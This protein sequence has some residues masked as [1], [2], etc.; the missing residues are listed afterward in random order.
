[1]CRGETYCRHLRGGPRP[2]LPSRI[3]PVPLSSPYSRE[4]EA[5]DREMDVYLLNV[6]GQ[7]VV[8]G[9]HVAHDLGY[10]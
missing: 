5:D 4:N 2:S 6:H 8:F 7:D 3:L 1:M 9:G 10:T